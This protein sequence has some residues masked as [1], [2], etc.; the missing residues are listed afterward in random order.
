MSTP[1]L[2]PAVE[3]YPPLVNP[4]PN[5]LFPIVNWTDEG[6][7]PP[8]YLGEGVRVRTIN[9]G[10]ENSTG[11]WDAE[12][13]QQPDDPNAKKTGERPDFLD[14]FDPLTVWAYDQCDLT[15]PS[16][17]DVRANA[18]QWLRLMEQTDVEHALA[19][20]MLFD[21]G[22]PLDTAT[23]LV[24]AV[25]QLEALLG[26]T[27]TLG[28]IH[29]S[30]AF[31]AVAAQSMLIVR[32]GSVLKTPLGHTWAFGGGYTDGLGTAVV[33]TS[34]LF[35][36]RNSVDVHETMKTEY[37]QFVAVAE[38]SFVVGYESLVGAVNVTG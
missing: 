5:G 34:Q 23:T 19:L 37:N 17:D 20:R 3:F 32:S 26:V 28:V 29:A 14:P 11:V 21:A 1:A 24:D 22:S 4:S 25:G 15:A 9:Y 27:N 31:A 12:W 33:A 7:A 2:L 6:D 10:G 13:C 38:R 35:G 16:R 30:A 18:Q 36:W 8:R